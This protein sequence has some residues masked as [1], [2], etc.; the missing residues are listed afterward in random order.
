MRS[1]LVRAVLAVAATMAGTT[2]AGAQ[3]VLNIYN[4]ND[5]VA[6]E[7]IARFERETGIKVTYDVYDS[8]EMLDAKLRT[9]RSGYDLVVPSASPFLAQQI[10]AKLFQPLERGKLPNY[11]NLDPAIMAQLARSDPG[12]RF[13]VPWMVGTTGIGYNVDKIKA[14]MQIGRAHV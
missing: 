10:P 9:R 4:W 5:Y 12:N 6:P 14:I 1:W 2:I 8:N 7:T 11:R 13:A 3:G